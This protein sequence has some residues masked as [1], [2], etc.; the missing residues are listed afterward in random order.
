[1]VDSVF[2]E[3]LNWDGITLPAGVSKCSVYVDKHSLGPFLAAEI[4]SFV[5]NIPA[6]AAPA[7]A[8]KRLVGKQPPGGTLVVGDGGGVRGILV[9]V[10]GSRC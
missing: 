3:M 9:A 8:A 2:E 10:D 1:M 7:R 5:A 6:P 4:P